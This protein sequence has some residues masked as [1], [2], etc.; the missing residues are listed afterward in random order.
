MS[1]VNEIKEGF[2]IGAKLYCYV[3]N[4]KEVIT[5]SAGIDPKLLKVDE[6]KNYLMEKI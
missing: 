3:N 1:L 6:F 5:A 4:K 2:F